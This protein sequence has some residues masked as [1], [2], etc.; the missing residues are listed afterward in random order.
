M[1]NNLITVNP[2]SLSEEDKEIYIKNIITQLGIEKKITFDPAE[3]EIVKFLRE[4]YNNMTLKELSS[5]LK[6]SVFFIRNKL[7][8][9]NLKK[10]KIKKEK[11]KKNV[12][13][14]SDEEKEFIKI[15]ANTLTYKEMSKLL[16]KSIYLI[17]REIK[18]L[19]IEKKKLIR[20]S[21]KKSEPVFTNREIEFIKA[22]YENMT[23]NELSIQ[24]DI[25]KW[26][27]QILIKKLGLKKRFNPGTLK[28]PAAPLWKWTGFN[29]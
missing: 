17:Q 5:N 2:T 9:L 24:L 26:K 11:I 21:S 15:R 7:I 14:L 25:P 12:I 13:Q 18:S 27:I 29:G 19:G 6:K 4:N 10:E 16:N 23:Q 22:N 28:A 8:A 3:E 20:F 1:E